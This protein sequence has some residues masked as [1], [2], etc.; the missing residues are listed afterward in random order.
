MSTPRR[1][2]LVGVIVALPLGYALQEAH[3]DLRNLICSGPASSTRPFLEREGVPPCGDW[4]GHDGSQ[5]YVLA[6]N[7]GD[8]KAT[9]PYVDAP[10]YR[11]KRIAWPLMLAP[12]GPGHGF[13][14]AALVLNLVM[15]AASGIL[16]MRL[17]QRAR[18][19]LWGVVG[20][21]FSPGVL[22]AIQLSLAD[23]AAM[24]FGLAAVAARKRW[25][26]VGW[27]C[28]AVLTRETALLMVLALLLTSRDRRYFLPVGVLAAWWFATW[29]TLDRRPPVGMEEGAFVAPF[30]DWFAWGWQH[31]IVIALMVA[32]TLW[33]AFRIGR[34]IP[35]L[36][37]WM[38]LDAALVVV[39]NRSVLFSGNFARVLMLT[40]TGLTLALA[41][42]TRQAG[43][44]PQRLRASNPAA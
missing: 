30:S 1:L 19:P 11:A 42:A 16:L 8:L 28:A 18:L 26:S 40:T 44:A 10:A 14:A 2:L 32:A 22:L 27:C 9:E 25:A 35:P 24:T 34:Y 36:G 23:I 37:L 15:L 12:F 6:R 7:I 43:Q 5:F 38:A 13:A 3:G 29:A 21:G 31:G 41:A 20:L 39:I 17:A 33:A 4:V